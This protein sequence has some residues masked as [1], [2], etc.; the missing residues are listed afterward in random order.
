M[1]TVPSCRDRSVLQ[2]P[3]GCFASLEKIG[4]ETI[5]FGEGRMAGEVFRFHPWSREWIAESFWKQL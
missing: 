5:D 2:F 1:Y 3:A 4:T